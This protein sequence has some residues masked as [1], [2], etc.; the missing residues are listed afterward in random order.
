MGI[1]GIFHIIRRL[2][3]D[4]RAATA[5]EFAMIGTAFFLMLFAIF[6][7][8]FDMF[9]QMTLDDAARNAARQVQIW[10]ENGT[11]STGPQFKAA[12]CAEF[13]AVAPSCSAL[14]QYSVQVGTTFGAMN[15]VTLSSTGNLS[16]PTQYVISGTTSP[17][18]TAEGA[19][20]FMLVQ[21][22][23]PI[24]FKFLNVANGVIT[25]NGTPSLYSAVA[26]VIP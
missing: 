5:L 26:T 9:L 18:A 19:P 15:T 3:G 22:A 6:T 21:I 1:S 17:L 20:A 11:V 4:R 2:R 14:L 24:P 23:Y 12:V 25:E 8:A 13:G 7:V 16:S 10:G